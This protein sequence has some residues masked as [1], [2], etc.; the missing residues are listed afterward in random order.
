MRQYLADENVESLVLVNEITSPV[1]F[2]PT[3]GALYDVREDH[4]LS[5]QSVLH[6]QPASTSCGDRQQ[7]RE[8]MLHPSVI[9][10]QPPPHMQW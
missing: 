3:R 8:T 1:D 5:S 4:T 6:L 2:P 7:S 9:A 10:T